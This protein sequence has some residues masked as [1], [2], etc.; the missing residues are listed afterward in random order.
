MKKLIFLNLKQKME[1]NSFRMISLDDERTIDRSFNHGRCW[2]RFKRYLSDKY[3]DLNMDKVLDIQIVN[4]APTIS[5]GIIEMM[6]SEDKVYYHMF[7]KRNTVEYDIVIRGY[8]QK[9]QLF[10]LL[11][12][13]SKTER[14][15]ILECEFD[16]LW[17]DYWIDHD[18]KGSYFNLKNQA[19]RRFDELKDLM[20]II[21]EEIPCQIDVVPFIFPKGR[22]NEREKPFETACREFLEETKHKLENGEPYFN[23]PITQTYIGSDNIKYMDKYFVVE[24]DKI[25]SSPKQDISQNY[26]LNNPLKKER[27]ITIGHELES[28][29]W[30]EI[31]KFKSKKDQWEWE[32]SIDPYKAFGIFKRHFSLLI[33]IHNHVC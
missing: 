6:I 9:H 17:D 33:Q 13:L 10:E 24:V 30:I 4:R 25:Y 27:S 29:I 21:D 32:N 18:P 28:D 16:D 26:K 19:L 20:K 1:G 11:S 12:L 23:S 14:R 22:A 3:P 31:P 5:Y 15:K 2:N 8:S 7:R